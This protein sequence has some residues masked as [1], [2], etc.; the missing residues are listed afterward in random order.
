MGFPFQAAVF[1]YRESVCGEEF[2]QVYLLVELVAV[3]S[4]AIPYWKEQY[5]RKK[6]KVKGNA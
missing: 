1:I 6:G 4:L 2:F 5:F 3:E